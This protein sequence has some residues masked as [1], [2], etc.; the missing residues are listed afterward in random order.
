[1]QQLA[2]FQTD[3]F[4]MH[5][6]TKAQISP[7]TGTWEHAAERFLRLGAFDMVHSQDPGRQLRLWETEGW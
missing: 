6:S 4:L 5:F 7:Q 1:M 2:G 3:R